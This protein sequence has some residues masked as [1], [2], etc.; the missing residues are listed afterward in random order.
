VADP[1]TEGGLIRID[2]T[3]VA[4]LRAD[5]LL[6]VPVDRRLRDQLL[7]EGRADR[8]PVVPTATRV[9]YRIG[10]PAD[11]S[12]CPT[13]RPDHRDGHGFRRT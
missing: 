9:S 3:V 2:E 10:G 4:G 6:D 8:H 7:T 1:P 11:V 13:R 12:V 5:G